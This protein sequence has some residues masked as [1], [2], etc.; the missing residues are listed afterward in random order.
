[1]IGLDVDSSPRTDLT[2]SAVPAALPLPAP[3]DLLRVTTVVAGRHVLLLLEGDCDIASA[4]VLEAAAAAV[5]AGVRTVAV[6]V[7]RLAFLD[8]AGLQALLAL[9]PGGQPP[10]LVDPSRPVRY[11]LD[12]AGQAGVLPARLDVVTTEG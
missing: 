9:A 7:S 2:A 11:L 3:A 1:M 5:P 12:V 10:V 4:R 8:C 6:D